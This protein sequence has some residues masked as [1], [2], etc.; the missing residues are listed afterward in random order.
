[1]MKTIDME[2]ALANYFGIRQNLIV[3]NVS[4]GM[5]THECDL[6]ILTPA[7]YGSE[8]EIKVSKADLLKDKEKRHGHH[9]PKIKFLYFAIP[10][11]LTRYVD[12][13]PSRAGVI[14]VSQNRHGRIGDT[15]EYCDC[16]KIRR[17]VVNSSYKYT[18]SERL[19]LA[20]LGAL[21]IWG[22]KKKLSKTCKERMVL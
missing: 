17:P 11:Y 12:D 21:R 22:L 13:I 18:D 1:M 10:D 15:Y 4:W 6:F 20:R 19:Q 2:I 8:I 3:P 14:V 7:G 5:E 9:S 16:T